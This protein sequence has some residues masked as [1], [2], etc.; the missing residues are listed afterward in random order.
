V[1]QQGA[2]SEFEK[3]FFNDLFANVIIPDLKC[4]DK[5]TDSLVDTRV[6]SGKNKQ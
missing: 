5:F 6:D 3:A 1:D 2:S 4:F